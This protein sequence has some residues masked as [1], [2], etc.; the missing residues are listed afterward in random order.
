MSTDDRAFLSLRS[1]QSPRE[2]FP[3]LSMKKKKKKL[4]TFNSFC[5]EG[6]QTNCLFCF[7]N[8]QKHGLQSIYLKK[9]NKIHLFRQC[10]HF[11]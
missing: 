10:V 8:P 11:G 4:L 7:Q 2:E 3:L 9:K 5:Y 1:V 6:S